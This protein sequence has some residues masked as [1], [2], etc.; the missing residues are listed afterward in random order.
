M[1]DKIP[2]LG[3]SVIHWFLTLGES[4]SLNSLSVALLRAFGQS[5]I[6]EMVR[7]ELNSLIR[8]RLEQAYITTLK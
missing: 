1:T 8:K 3:H 4:P 5:Y 7:M 6:F 2:M